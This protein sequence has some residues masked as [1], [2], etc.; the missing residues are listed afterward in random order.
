MKKLI[1]SSLLITSGF[2]FAYIQI[3]VDN[4]NYLA[5]NNIITTQSKTAGYRLDASISRAEV[6]AIALKMKGIQDP[7][8]YKCKKYFSDTVQNDWICRA[9]ELAADN[10][11]IT[12]N[13]KFRP[14]DKITKI[15]ALTILTKSA[16]LYKKA[17]ES[18]LPYAF[19]S[20]VEWQ[21]ELLR[22]VFGMQLFK[23]NDYK[24]TKKILQPNEFGFCPGSIC[25]ITTIFFYPDNNATRAEVFG[26]AKNILEYKTKIMSGEAATQ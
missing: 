2:A 6:V 9:V 4:A 18:E 14:Q 17:T 11:I 24:T 10:G 15:E 20:N 19:D 7:P 8:S 16:G 12:R 1:L 5:S 21:L 3:D 25:E 26:F 22:G 23:T 13:K